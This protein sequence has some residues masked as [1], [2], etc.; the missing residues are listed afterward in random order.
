MTIA[1]RMRRPPFIGAGILGPLLGLLLGLLHGTVLVAATIPTCPGSPLVLIQPDSSAL[2]A[3]LTLWGG[4]HGS[5]YGHVVLAAPGIYRISN[6][7]RP[8]PVPFAAP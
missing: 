3:I 8:T 2:D 5:C 1:G 7:V 6:E 4:K